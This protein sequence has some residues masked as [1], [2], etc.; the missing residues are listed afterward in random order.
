MEGLRVGYAFGDVE[1]TAELQ[2]E[3]T[4]FATYATGGFTVGVQTSETT[5]GNTTADTES[6]IWY[7]TAANDDLAVSYGAHS[8]EY[9]TGDDQEAAFISYTMGSMALSGNSVDKC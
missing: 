8:I 9:A 6:L 2:E 4:M 1:T 3:S 5:E 7:F